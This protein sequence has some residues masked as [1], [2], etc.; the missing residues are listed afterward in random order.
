MY[1]PLA[2]VK[3]NKVISRRGVKLNCFIGILTLAAA[4]AEAPTI[5]PPGIVGLELGMSVKDVKKTRA[6][7]DIQSSTRAFDPVER[8][9]LALKDDKVT[10]IRIFIPTPTSE[11]VQQYYATHFK[12]AR[13]SK[14]QYE[15]E[16][17]IFDI[18][19]SYSLNNKKQEINLIDNLRNSLKKIIQNRLSK[20]PFTNINIIRI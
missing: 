9:A 12:D 8:I 11:S 4:C 15:I 17:K 18:C 5:L 14:Y 19:K 20:K 6:T 16:D 3:Q 10:G 2:T 1:H 13:S 7:M